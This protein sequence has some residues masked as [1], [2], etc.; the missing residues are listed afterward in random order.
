M[1]AAAPAP[2]RWLFAPI[3]DLLLGCGLLYA[4]LFVLFGVAGP[5]LRTL[6]LGVALRLGVILF[7]MP[8]YGATLLRVYEQ[9]QERRR[10]AI[11][12]VWTTLLV[13]ALFVV[14]VYNVLIASLLVTVYLTWS[15]WHYTGQN[16]GLAVMFLRRR[17]VDLTP[18]LKR[19]VYSSFV[20]SFVLTFL[21]LHGSAAPGYNPFAYE[22]SEVAFLPLGI[23]ST[24]GKVLVSLVGGAYLVATVVAGFLLLRRNGFR[25]IGPVAALALTQALWFSV[26]F[27]VRYFGWHTGIDP[28][29]KHSL[30]ADY[31]LLIFIGHGIQY[32]WVTAYYARAAQRWRGY[33]NYWLKTLACGTAIWTLPVVAFAADGIGKLSFDGGMALLV[34]AGVNIH[35]FILDGAI[36]KLRNSRIASVLIRNENQEVASPGGGPWG[37][38]AVWAVAGL[39]L[40]VTFFEFYEFR[41]AYPAAVRAGDYA[42]AGAILD[43]LAWVGHD[44]A[45]H[46][47]KLGVGYERAGDLETAA[48]YYARSLEL[49]PSARLWGALGS[50][51]ERQEHWGAAI[52]AYQSALALDDS[53]AEFLH[54]A[55]A[56]IARRSGDCDSAIR[57]YRDA[58]RINP[59]SRRRSNDLAWALATCPDADLRAP[60]ESVRLAE[61]V[62]DSGEPDPTVL[63]TLAAAY[64]AAGRFD[65][66]VRTASQAVELADA[67]G[68]ADLRRDID[69]KLALYRER[70]PFVEEPT[71]SGGG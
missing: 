71:I 30:I 45:S 20:L 59:K 54:G 41:V 23:P 15:P 25:D 53:R 3:P 60:D 24:I 68:E 32:L 12:S 10:Y 28:I 47:T 62:R 17:G 18:T 19:W 13:G 65:E 7:S 14:G 48:R 5:D 4:A 37:R 8:H 27:A 70:R 63:D 6:D 69:T 43:R 51:E 33:W 50:V 29:D 36:W 46:R 64:A 49:H 55:L 61:G 31:I 39:G 38:R 2:S 57:H 1:A 40:V 11:F 34:A 42:G 66:A 26:P 44:R 21:V 58:L 9:R 56:S 16:Y 67:R 22:A 35:H 52:A